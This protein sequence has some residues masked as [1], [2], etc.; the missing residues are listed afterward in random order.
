ML[1]HALRF[2]P[3]EL[4]ALTS[5]P[6][7][8]STAEWARRNVRVPDGPMA[9]TPYDPDLTPY[10]PPLWDLLMQ[11]WVREMWGMASPQVGKTLF[12]LVFLA[13]RGVER[14]APRMLALPDETQQERVFKLKAIPLYERSP[15]LRRYLGGER[16]AVS[17]EEIGLANGAVLLGS[18]AGSASKRASLSVMDL[19]QDE[20]DLYP[21]AAVADYL[22][23]VRAYGLLSK[24]L[25][26]GKPLGA[27]KKSAIHKALQQCDVVL[28]FEARCPRCGTFQEMAFERIK[29]PPGV[30]DAEAI[31]TRKLAWYECAACAAPWSDSTRNVAAAA[32]RWK[33][34][35]EV[36]RPVKVGWRL[37]S[38]YSRFVS[39]S[40]VM[41]AW[42]AAQ[43]NA[44]A[45]AS[46][47][48]G[49]AAQP[50]DAL[51][52]LTTE[53]VVR[54]RYVLPDLAPLRVPVEACVLTLSADMQKDHFK[55]SVAAHA[56]LRHWVIDY[57]RLG[58]W[59]E[60]TAQ[61]FR[62]RYAQEGAGRE[63]AIWRAGVDTGGTRENPW[64]ESRTME[65][66]RWLLR[67]RPGVVFGTKGMSRA[68]P[69]VFVKWSLL[70]R[71]PDGTP[72][73]RGLRLYQVDTDAMKAA[74]FWMLS[75][76][77][78]EEGL[79]FHNAT[80]EDFLREVLSEKQIE[81]KGKLVWKRVRANH[82]L[83]TLVGH[84]A[85]VHWQWAPSLEA[86]AGRGPRPVGPAKT[87]A[88]PAAPAPGP[89]A[90]PGWWERRQF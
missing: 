6:G 84:L 3:G 13:R 69:G 89:G 32:G 22:E 34:N 33:A 28:H 7:P 27:E 52:T 67:Q 56:K 81:V 8:E 36:A 25:G 49:Y 39:L 17:T 74:I 21:P 47:W 54:A 20:P 40:E 76:E 9:G 58:S 50:Y 85:M 83:D 86:L 29:V 38:W 80:G 16:Y 77:E 64:E 88:R 65:A 42:F 14:P 57:G 10:F 30:R 73:R 11:P 62:A 23:R 51:I 43:G 5:G 61:I 2:Y 31:R 15:R 79:F 87:Q 66:Y 90:R 19:V 26:I 48:N 35:R 24:V 44:E 63:M 37:P 68:T 75:E 70:E 4:E 82:F 78:T 12:C 1:E 59:E 60:L 46:W 41:A 71:F 45:L 53:D 18:W 72:M 55:Y